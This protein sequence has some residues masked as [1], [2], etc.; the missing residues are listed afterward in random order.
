MMCLKEKAVD[1]KANHNYRKEHNVTFTEKDTSANKSYIL[2][3]NEFSY[4]LPCKYT[5]T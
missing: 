5:L 3:E 4:G 1:P 2:P